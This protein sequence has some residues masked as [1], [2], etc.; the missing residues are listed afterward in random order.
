MHELSGKQFGDWKII[1]RSTIPQRWVCRCKCEAVATVRQSDLL[2]GKSKCCRACGS[3]KHGKQGTPTY[4]SWHSMIQRCTNPKSP[5]YADYG[6]MGVSVCPAWLTFEG[7][8]RDMGERPAGMT[9]DR[10]PDKSGDYEPGNCRWATGKQQ[11]RNK[12]NNS[13]VTFR[14][15][16]RLLIDLSEEFGV[17][18]DT[19]AGR[20]R[21]GWDV[22]RAVTSPGRVAC[23]K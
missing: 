15:E 6:A 14:G 8:F 10:F 20:L 17:H 7:F 1:C 11:Q 16:V 4:E 23:P 2:N 21:R 12:A 22:E 19:I 13:T 18:R 9:L 5:S 3:T